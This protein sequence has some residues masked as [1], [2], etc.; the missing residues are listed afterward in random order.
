M[1]S[2]WIE[3]GKAGEERANPASLGYGWTCNRNAYGTSTS[4][5]SG[6]DTQVSEAR[7]ERQ[8]SHQP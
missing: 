5:S 4:I 6:M 2:T 1:N 7:G 8:N 3:A